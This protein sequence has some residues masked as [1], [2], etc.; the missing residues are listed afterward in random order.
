MNNVL[1]VGEREPL[2][3]IEAEAHEERPVSGRKTTRVRA[4][5]DE[6]RVQVTAAHVLVDHRKIGQLHAGAN[7][8]NDVV[9]HRE[10]R[11]QTQA[12]SRLQTRAT[13]TNG[14]LLLTAHSVII[15]ASSC[16]PCSVCK[17]ESTLS[18]GA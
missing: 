17:S 11:R 16:L 2:G 6:Q 9:V 15:F 1:R 18:P 10:L 3:R 5:F 13:Q 8:R 12:A 14:T 4:L 7:K